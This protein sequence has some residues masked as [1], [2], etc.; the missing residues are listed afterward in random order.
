MVGLELTYLAVIGQA[1]VL[2]SKVER[3]LRLCGPLRDF[4]R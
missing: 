2:G 3:N 4:N 1:W